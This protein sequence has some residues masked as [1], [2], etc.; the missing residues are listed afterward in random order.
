VNTFVE[1]GRPVSTVMR[2]HTDGINFF[3]YGRGNLG[4]T[5]TLSQTDLL[6]EQRIPLTWRDVTMHIGVNVTNVFD[7]M[8]VL[9]YQVTPYLDALKI[10]ATEFFAGFDPAAVVAVTPSIRQDPRYRM[11][12][13]YQ[14]RRSILAQARITF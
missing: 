1:S 4:R 5:P 14:T 13:N 12:S 2:M 8:T 10:S 9:N 3:P 6:V 7:Q 11:A